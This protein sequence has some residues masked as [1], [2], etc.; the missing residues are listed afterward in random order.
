M[1]QYG[2]AW[3]FASLHKLL[4]TV[5]AVSAAEVLHLPR[6]YVVAPSEEWAVGIVSAWR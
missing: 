3:I 6:Y 5:A 4:G 1:K 2:F